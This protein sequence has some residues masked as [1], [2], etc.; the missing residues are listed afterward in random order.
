MRILSLIILTTILT[1]CRLANREQKSTSEPPSQPIASDTLVL[2]FAGDIMQH[3]AQID[4]AKRD[5]TYNYDSYFTHIQEEI[6]SA[7]LAI[8]NLETTIAGPPYTGYPQFSAPTQ[9]L[10]AIQKAGFDLLLTAN[11]H[12]LDRYSK[13]LTQTLNSLDSLKIAHIGSYRDATDRKQRDPYIITLKDIKL[14]FL[15]Y[16]YG[17]N[18]IPVKSPQLVNY[19]D[20]TLI[21]QDIALAKN[22][23]S[24]AIIVCIHWG[25]EYETKPNKSQKQLAEW[26]IANGVDHIIGSHPHVIQPIDIIKDPKERKNHIVVYSKGNFISNMSK[27]GTDGGLLFKLK[28]FKVEDKIEAK[29]SYSLVWVGR[30]K[31]TGEKNFS[32]FPINR[33]RDKLNT[34]SHNR[35]IF[36]QKEA[37]TVMKQNHPDIKEYFL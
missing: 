23:K 19:I 24:E 36:F 4:A 6:Q 27:K 17:T 37:N 32:L 1:S 14:A 13:G 10:T 33:E 31:F 5:S 9:L 22:K 30:P 28:L 35:L 8:A 15:N 29:G 20:T 16:T 25:E 26:L 3:Q 2:L 11:N 21:K 12:I 18:G 34:N 7:D